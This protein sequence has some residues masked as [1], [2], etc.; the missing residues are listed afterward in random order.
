METPKISMP[1]SAFSCAQQNKSMQCILVF[2][3]C[4]ALFKHSLSAELMEDVFTQGITAHLREPV[5]SDGV[6]VT[7]KGGVINGPD[8]RIQA[9][10][11][12]YTRKVVDKIPV[13]TI[14][15]EGDL[16]LEFGNYIF[17]GERLEYNFQTKSGVIY[18]GRTMVEPWYFGGERIDL[19]PDG[20]YILHQAFISTSENYEP[21][22]EI[23][24]EKVSLNQCQDLY[25]KNIQFRIMKLPILWI[26]SFKTNLDSI[27]DAPIRY[28][29]R[30]GGRQGPRIG[31][32][33]EF[34][35]WGRWKTFLRFDYRLKRGPGLG[36]ETHYK[37]EDHKT[38]FETI[39]YVARDSSINHPSERYRYRFQGMYNDL[40]VNDRISVRLTY[41]KLSDQDMATD[42]RDSGI[43]LDTAGRTQLIARHQESRWI[44]NFLTR[45][46]VNNFQTIKQELPTFENSWRPFELGSTGIISDNQ[47]KASYIDFLYGNNLI[48]VHD[49][50]STR[51]E[52][53]S[54]LYKPF[55]Y[56]QFNITPGIGAVSILYGNSPEKNPKYLLLGQ[57][58][59]EVN[60]H[61]YRHYRNVKH[62]IVPY[63]NYDYYT[64]PTVSPND[65]FIFD[66]E[67]GWYRLDQLRFGLLQSL[68]FKAC[69]HCISRYLYV[70]LYANAFFDTKTIPQVVPKAYLDIVFNSLPTLRH[71]I[72]TAWDFGQS[73]LDHYN[74]R[75]EW[76]INPNAALAL[77]YRHRDAFD[78]RKVDHTNFILDSFRSISELRRSALSD[79]RDTLLV[80][81]FYRFHPTWAL[82][83]QSRSGWNRRREPSYTEFEVDFLAT[84]RSSWNVKLSYQHKEN[85]DRVAI[86]MNIGVKRPDRKDPCSIIPCLEF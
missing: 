62:V 69:N 47:M 78:W 70:D 59:C 63:M 35:K 9:Q 20:S 26:P 18:D 28:N 49:Y 74:L 37:S 51:L 75:T 30:W 25:A 76:T 10:K 31:L 40:L 11:M 60:T 17:V 42:Y 8:L 53:A 15:A 79:R 55:R 86:Y 81:F 52:L 84:L 85:D 43:E 2:F 46:R 23:T 32:L 58:C 13:F 72:G 61:L 33:Y 82:E 38:S 21:E 5:Y 57:F 67:D 83:F 50:R 12:V 77:E 44:A 24:S 29:F 1:L 22:W 45:V 64:Y 68:Y 80:H 16:V 36:F 65:H 7:D 66:I 19:C 48:R 39:N 34:F 27:F 6:L 73:Q 14:E 54:N 3:L 41:D 4:L 56:R 71:T